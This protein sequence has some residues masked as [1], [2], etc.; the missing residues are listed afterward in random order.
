MVEGIH[1]ERRWNRWKELGAKILSVNLSD[2]AAMGA[3]KPLA[4]LV[5]AAIPGD[6]PV[7]TVDKLYSGIESCARRWKTG[8]LGGDTVGSDGHWFISITVIGEAD[9][10]ALVRRNGARAGDLMASTGPLGLAA[11]GL[12]VLQSGKDRQA[13]TRPL[14]D[15]FCSPQPRFKEGALLATSKLATSMLD[16]S[17][18]LTASARLLAEASGTGVE[19]DVQKLPRCI[20]L[21]RWAQANN[22][23]AWEYALS[24][25]EDYEL[26]FTVNPKQWEQVK[27]LLP[28]AAVVGRV[29]PRASGICAVEAGRRWRL[30]GY[31][32]S[33]FKK[34]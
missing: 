21:E 15:A 22:R 4:A 27:R 24:G 34:R 29:V 33:H 32:Y 5:T 7:H 3:V 6:T 28:K 10:S 1:F 26:I 25:G 23:H 11:G 19:L 20:A 17:D 12:E 30:E 2:L 8:L 14:V 16:C 9:R 13:W 18:G 31:G